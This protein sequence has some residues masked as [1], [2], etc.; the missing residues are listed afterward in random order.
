[1]VPGHL[2]QMRQHWGG[3][4]DFDD[5]DFFTAIATSAK[6]MNTAITSKLTNTAAPAV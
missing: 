1:M 3:F 2:I 4:Q 6:T 5:M